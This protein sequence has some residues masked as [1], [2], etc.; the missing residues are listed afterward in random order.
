MVSKRGG[1]LSNDIKW[2]GH[3][4]FE[5]I[6]AK[7]KRIF[8]DPWLDGNPV[9]KVNLADVNKADLILV[10]HDHADHFADAVPLAK[11]TGAMIIAQP[12]II[13]QCKKMGINSEQLAH[14]EIGM[15]IGGTVV[16][17][18]IAITMVEA[19]HSS[20]AGSP[21]GYIIRTEDEKVIY[22]AGD[23]GVFASMSI[24]GS[25][26]QPDLALLPIGSC[27]TM[28]SR[29]AAFA[30][31]LLKPKTVIPMHY[32]TFPFLE[33]DT[34]NF[35]ELAREKTP[36]VKVVILEPGENYNI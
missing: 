15:N 35:V 19:F 11:K 23:T 8:I 17:K 24:I 33:Q 9:C 29:Q 21:C 31:E 10:T 14:N 13:D 5:I 26:Y 1:K 3:A 22:H 28:D 16:V 6:S 25:I 20:E 18:D 4:S 2:L 27:F 12:E 34:Q 36:N 7:G 30:L 32:K